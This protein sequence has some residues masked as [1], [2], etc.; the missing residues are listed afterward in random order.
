MFGPAHS[1]SRRAEHFLLTSIVNYSWS[2]IFWTRPARANDH[3]KANQCDTQLPGS[4]AITSISGLP[5]QTIFCP[6]VPSSRV[7]FLDKARSH[8]WG[9]V[10]LRQRFVR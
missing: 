6:R 1:A 7:H 3:G 10:H 8:L 4:Q 5:V 2:V 9:L